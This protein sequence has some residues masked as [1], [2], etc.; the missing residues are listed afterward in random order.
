MPRHS[1]QQRVRAL[2]FVRGLT[3]I[4]MVAFHACTMPYASMVF[5]SISF[6]TSQYRRFGEQASAGLFYS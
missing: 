1:S 6:P 4:S 5:R 2:D 3:V